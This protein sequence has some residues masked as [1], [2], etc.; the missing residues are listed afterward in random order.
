M[1]KRSIH[2]MPEFFDRYINLVGEENL[3]DALNHSLQSLENINIAA[4]QSIGHK[5]YAPGKWT[6]Q[7]ILQHITDNERIQAYRALRFARKD[8]TPLPGYDE[9][10]FAAHAMAAY[11]KTEDLLEELK[12]LRRS[13]IQLFQSFPPSALNNTGICFNKTVSV[14]ALGFVIIGHQEHHLNVI[15]E[16]YEPLNYSL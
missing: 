7:D 2:P 8:S 12:T 13:T 4:W 11:R 1:F 9:N 3:F 15:R 5:V 6:L 10:E 14:L 16:K